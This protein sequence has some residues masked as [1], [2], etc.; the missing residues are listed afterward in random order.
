MFSAEKIKSLIEINTKLNSNYAEPDKVLVYILESAMCLVECESSSILL[1]NREGSAL[2]FAVALGPKGA[3]AKD[4]PVDTNSIAGWVIANNQ[5]VI[6]DDVP[7]D[8]RFN[9]GVQDK[10]NYITKNMIATP[11]RIGNDCIGVIELINKVDG[12]K[13][14]EDD[15]SILELVGIQAGNAYRNSHFYINTRESIDALQDSVSQGKDFHAFIAKSPII[16]DTIKVIEEASK[17]NSSVLI[18]GESGVGKELFA[19]QLHLKSPRREK[20]FVRVS[21]AALSQS[22]LESE[23]FGHVKGAYTNAINAQKGRFEVA[24]GGT[25]FLDEIGEMPLELQADRK[26]VV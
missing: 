15:V 14:T 13:F 19:E 8:T 23:L 1:L 16:L 26:S 25:L 9:R 20:P 12:K 22:I 3:E 5:S 24:D 4:V 11:I 10:T 21:C 7:A 2:H 17:V 18:L 6:V